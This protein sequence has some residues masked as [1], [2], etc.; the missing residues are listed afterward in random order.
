MPGVFDGVEGPAEID[1]V[2]ELGT[3]TARRRLTQHRDSFIT[4]KDFRWIKRHGFDFVRLPVGYWLFKETDDFIDG[5][6][7]LRKAFQWAAK[8]DLKIVLDFHGLPGSQ[9]G[10]D[11]SG[12]VGPV[13]LYQ[14]ENQQQALDTLEYMAQTYGHEPALIGLELINEPRAKFCLWRLLR[15]Y[16]KAIA[17]VAPYLRP[18]A[19]IIVSDAFRPL[20][21]AKKL[22]NRPYSNRLVLDVHLYQVYS[23]SDQRHSFDRH[24]A[25]ADESWWDLIDA[26]Q[27]FVPVMV[28]EWSAAL[29][30][31][32]Y[33]DGRGGE[34]ER[35]SRY[36]EA[37]KRTFDDSAW[38][39]AY[40]T[41]KAPHCGVW[42]WRESR[43]LLEP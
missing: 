8:H 28:G 18:E 29:P 27:K 5:E 6:V 32:A 41:Y 30:Q 23:R 36:Y 37:Q 26:I 21:I 4:E 17:L 43:T 14:R 25:I 34:Q 19:K 2:R 1:L 16:D 11:H 10:K 39:H 31:A 20:A 9:N 42:S 7:Y 3:E 38:A 15:Y 40:W 12:Q 35:V 24:V 33:S 22:P 13:R